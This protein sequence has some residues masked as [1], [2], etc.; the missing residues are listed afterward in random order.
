MVEHLS[1]RIAPARV[2][3]RLAEILDAVDAGVTVQDAH[4]R[5]V[6]AN[7]AAARLTGWASAEAMLAA[8]SEET[9]GR[10][11]MMDEQGQA[12]DPSSLPARRILAGETPDP[13]VVTVSSADTVLD[14][15]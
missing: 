7:Q 12:L 4:L 10:F 5:L 13:L 2:S 6:Y 1:E 11:E 14:A 9:L 8:T 15:L 3:I